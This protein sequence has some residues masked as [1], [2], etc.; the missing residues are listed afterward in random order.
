MLSFRLSLLKL[1]DEAVLPAFLVVGTK[2]I[3]FLLVAIFLGLKLPLFSDLP[4]ILFLTKWVS[5]DYEKFVQVSSVSSM[6]T[7]LVLLI[8]FGWVI[9]KAHHFHDSHISPRYHQKLV[10][11]G[12]EHLVESS[13]EI[14][15]QALVWFT[16]T[17][18]FFFYVIVSTYA[19]LTAWWVPLIGTAVVFS[20][21]MMM[22]E[23]VINEVKI[24]KSA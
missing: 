3:S 24:K 17:W 10:K 6:F 2:I 19:G 8:F 5:E 11:N 13:Q 21:T 12:W 14:Y 22:V 18:L 16:L 7:F 9:I 4:S 1:F 15:H 23:D 20:L